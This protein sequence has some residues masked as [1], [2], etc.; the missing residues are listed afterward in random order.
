MKGLPTC[1]EENTA[2]V[3]AYSS[4]MEAVKRPIPDV[5]HGGWKAIRD[6]QH[7]PWSLGV[8]CCGVL[9]LHLSV[10]PSGTPFFRGPW[11]VWT[12]RR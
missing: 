9:P 2:L 8:A 12:K 5:P 7:V 6:K 1:T 11:S 10:A 3:S 4:L